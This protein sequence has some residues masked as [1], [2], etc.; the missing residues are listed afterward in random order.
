M[1]TENT[2]VQLCVK[3]KNKWSWATAVIY[4]LFFVSFVSE[5]FTIR[6]QC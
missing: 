1:C 5:A 4:F 6:L 3:L 2:R